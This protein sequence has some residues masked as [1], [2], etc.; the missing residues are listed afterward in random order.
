VVFCVPDI[1]NRFKLEIKSCKFENRVHVKSCSHIS[2]HKYA[3][4]ELIFSR[5]M[6]GERSSYR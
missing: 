6:D 4:S 1:V 3:G 2:G 5:D